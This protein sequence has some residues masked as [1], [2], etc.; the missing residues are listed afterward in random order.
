[1]TPET[2]VKI[3]EIGRK[4][5]VPD[6]RKKKLVAIILGVCSALCFFVLVPLGVLYRNVWLSMAGLIGTLV[7]F[8]LFAFQMDKKYLPM[9]R[10]WKEIQ[11]K[12]GLLEEH[13]NLSGN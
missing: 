5:I 9:K 7:L 3:R 8:I 1:M 11:M 6:L 13:F 12:L 10:G 2:I 4:K